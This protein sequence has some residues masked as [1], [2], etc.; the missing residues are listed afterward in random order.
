MRVIS[1]SPR[2]DILVLSSAKRANLSL[3]WTGIL[4]DLTM[5]SLM[6]DTV[7]PESRVM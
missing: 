2:D 7:A 5:S 3:G 1:I 4:Y 6:K